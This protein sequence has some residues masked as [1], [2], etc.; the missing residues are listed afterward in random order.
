MEYMIDKE[1]VHIIMKRNHIRTQAELAAKMGMTKN[2][3]S[4]LLSCRSNPIKSNYQR[5]CDTL[6]VEPMDIFH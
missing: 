1:K 2:Q 5:L 3:L 4:V 6:G